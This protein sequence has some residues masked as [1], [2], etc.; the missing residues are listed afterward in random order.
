M[1][2]PRENSLALLCKL[3]SLVFQALGQAGSSPFLGLLEFSDEDRT[4]AQEAISNVGYGYEKEV[5]RILRKFQNFAAWYLCDAVRRSYGKEGTARVWPY[6]AEALSIE[7]KLSHPFRHA[8]H[9]I[10]AQRCK[11]LGLPV[12]RE[13]RVSLFRLHAG[14]SEAQLPALIRAFLAQERYYDLP[15]LDDGNALNEWE[16]DS[17]HFVPEGLKVL[18]E[19]IL[20]DVSAWHASVYADCRLGANHSK[21]VYHSNF[22]KL[23][24]TARKKPADDDARPRLVL[25]NMELA[26]RLPD[27]TSRQRVQFDELV[28]RMR[29]G[30]VRPLP[31]PLPARVTFDQGEIK[32]LPFPGDVFIGDRDLEGYI[33]QVRQKATLR[34]SNIVLFAREPIRRQN[35]DNIESYQIAEGLFTASLALPQTGTLGLYVGETPLAL[36]QE[37]CRRVSLKGGIIGRG[38]SGP[39][40]SSE[41]T[42]LIQT[43]IDDK[44]KREISVRL[45]AECE[46]IFEVQ[47]DAAGEAEIPLS[48]ILLAFEQLHKSGPLALRVELLRPKESEYAPA[49]GSG[50][51]MRADVW[52][53][54][55]DRNEV[56]LRCSLP[57]NNLELTDSENIVLDNS[58][59][60]CIDR[61]AASAEIV[62]EIEGKPRRYRLP[63]L[64]LNIVHIMPDGASRPMPIGA[65]IV[66]TSDALGGA[67]R[68]NSNDSDAELEI[69]GRPRFKP[70]RGGRAR[71]V[72]LRGLKS[73]WIK[74]HRRDGLTIDLV[75]IREE[76]TY[77][78]VDIKPR[79]ENV[80]I[81]LLLDGKLDGKIDA[82]HVEVEEEMGEVKFGEIHF[83]LEQFIERVPEWV[84]AILQA[85]GSIDI[86]ING[87]MLASGT[88]LGRL[89]AKNKAGWHSIVSAK[90]NLLTFI[91]SYGGAE[92]DDIHTAKRAKRVLG[93]LDICHAL[94]SM[95][96][97]GVVDEL[98]NRKSALVK[99]LDTLPGGR[100]K[101]INMSLNDDWLVVGSTWMPEM[102]ALL[103]CP[104]MFEGS[105][106]N[107]C[108]AG[109]AYEALALLEN[110]RLRE[111]NFIDPIAF[112]GF[113]NF[114]E[115]QTADEK[116]EGFDVK[117]LM[118]I[119]SSQEDLAKPRWNGRP[120]LGP[121]HWQSAHRLLQDRIEE[122]RF[123]DEDTEGNSG[124]RSSNLRRLHALTGRGNEKPPVPS[125]LSED[126]IQKR[127]HEDC[128]QTLGA[129]AV[130]ARS[131]ETNTWLSKLQS[132]TDMSHKALLGS[133]GDLVRLAPELFAFHLIAAELERRN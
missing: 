45:G 115:T 104:D 14:V 59:I 85:N 94:E 121:T 54:F 93:W 61:E 13:N 129:F 20:W 124:D 51:K 44:K 126:Q 90:G 89:Y 71:T 130:A 40:Y 10:V 96:E 109:G 86:S 56:Q 47:T 6:I 60:P 118:Q 65:N 79:S 74:L 98:T 23:I 68:I 75:E 123:F 88:W 31:L 91:T 112:A 127:I 64:D 19:P 21:T 8:L 107:F 55:L 62:F 73:G 52:P 15:P 36:E 97:G 110:Q 42:L 35:G 114:T 43:G 5:E 122:T 95:K 132:R 82:L 2:E 133:L 22:S 101:I 117:R 16:I 17:L 1:A 27:G 100:A 25:D 9:D 53:G 58:G 66:L 26:I 84:S 80:Q 108:N 81:N 12:P 105:I 116:L 49:V 125:F 83:G 4:N 119:V 72:S 76:F 11:E 77:H 46:H 37:L 111:L 57:L 38:S 7:S 102:H 131:Q 41:A 24:D 103:D 87:L 18:R 63:P 70:F 48:E 28:L 3:D 33:T 32:L 99:H 92:S 106:T 78:S 30:T 120:V 34:M 113:D 67:I 69:H 29:S 128:S 50:V 39:L